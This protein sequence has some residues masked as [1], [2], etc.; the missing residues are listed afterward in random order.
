VVSIKGGEVLVD[1]LVA[2]LKAGIPARLNLINAEYDDGLSLDA[3]KAFYTS[4]LSAIPEAPALIV[5]EGPMNVD[6]ELETPH[7]ITTDTMLGVYI[8]EQDPDRQLL[9][10]RLQRQARAVQEAAWDDAPQ[11]QLVAVNGPRS[12][13]VC[14]YKLMVEGTQPGRVFDPDTDD[15]W[16][17]F[18]LVTFRATQLEE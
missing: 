13:Q 3:P 5:A 11:E 1:A 2:K 8:L 12:G 17:G 18:Y 6:P 16:R 7:G 10:K 9:G 14:A 15:S 4:G